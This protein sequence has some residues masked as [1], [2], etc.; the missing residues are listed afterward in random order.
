MKSRGS[1]LTTQDIIKFTRVTGIWILTTEQNQDLWNPVVS[2][3]DR[4]LRVRSRAVDW[5]RGR[6]EIQLS[7]AGAGEGAGRL[8]ACAQRA[9]RD[10]LNTP[11]EVG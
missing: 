3:Q 6:A 8:L 2:S 5:S 10:D 7:P 4:K 11:D 9:S 1:L